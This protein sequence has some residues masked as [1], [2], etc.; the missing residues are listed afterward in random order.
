MLVQTYGCA[1]Y[2]IDAIPITIETNINRGIN[3]FLVG[4]PDSAVKESHQRIKAA[5]VNSSLKFPKQEITINMA[6]ADIRKEGSA[7]DLT[8]AAGILGASKQIPPEKLAD[9]LVMG[10]LSL[11]GDVR[12][13]KGALSMALKAKEMGLKGFIVPKQNAN[14]VAIVEGIKIYP[15]SCIRE[16]VAF[17][18]AKTDIKPAEYEPVEEPESVPLAGMDFSDVKGQQSVKRALEIAAS[19]GHNI[20]LIG[21]PGSG[22]T[23]LAK[24]LPTI[25]P[26]LTLDEALETTKIHSVAG[27]LNAKTGLVSIRPF[28]SPH[29]TISD[30]A[31]VG[32]ATPNRA[33]YH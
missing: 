26:P 8:I 22:K 3:F 9:F 5:L 17:M 7:Y 20:L 13:I 23:M 6:P 29:H 32:G 27:L 11:N 16:M 21:A 31:L 4:L 18:N 12:P 30:V 25:L 19:G 10:E 28:R 1:V 33:K 24:R 15:I 2:G 14:E